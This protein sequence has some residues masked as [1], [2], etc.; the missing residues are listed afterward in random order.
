MCV[1][2]FLLAVCATRW[3]AKVQND[4]ENEAEVY[5]PLDHPPG[6]E[7]SQTKA[8][9]KGDHNAVASQEAG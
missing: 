7:C 5:D 3:E 6:N 2:L 4:I 1:W 9:E 8:K